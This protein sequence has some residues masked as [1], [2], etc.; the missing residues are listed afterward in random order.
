M[1][2]FLIQPTVHSVVPPPPHTHTKRA[3]DVLHQLSVRSEA[4][5]DPSFRIWWTDYNLLINDT[6]ST[7]FSL[8]HS[9]SLSISLPFSLFA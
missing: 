8:T 1:Q 9:V 3:P 6:P 7:L 4:W 2:D 5:I